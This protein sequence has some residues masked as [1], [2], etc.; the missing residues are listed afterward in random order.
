MAAR[1]AKTI[2]KKKKKNCQNTS[3]QNSKMSQ[4]YEILCIL[5][6]SQPVEERGNKISF[7]THE[8]L[9]VLT[10]VHFVIF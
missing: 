6:V 3:I 5:V 10:F 7:L 2:V 1:Y 4:S 8:Y 9:S